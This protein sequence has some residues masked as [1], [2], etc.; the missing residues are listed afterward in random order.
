MVATTE[1]LVLPPAAALILF[2]A[3]AACE[4]PP[5]VRFN[6]T[7][8]ALATPLAENRGSADVENACMHAF[9]V[10]TV[11]HPPCPGSP[12]LLTPEIRGHAFLMP[13][14]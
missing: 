13:Q 5:L 4:P 14:T 9:I 11:R 10:A 8:M 12:S 2:T 1:W 3:A 7:L 6:L